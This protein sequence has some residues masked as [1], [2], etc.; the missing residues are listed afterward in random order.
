MKSNRL[1]IPRVPALWGL[2]ILTGIALGAFVGFGVNAQNNL[3]LF[4][5]TATVSVARTGT[6]SRVDF[7]VVS[8]QFSD[9]KNA[10]DSIVAAS[11]D[12]ANLTKDIDS[13]VKNITIK[14][15]FRSPLWKSIVLGGVVGGLVAFGAAWAWQNAQ[16]Y[17]SQQNNSQ[18][19]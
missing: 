18:G 6:V 8:D 14:G 5:A 13:E 3:P 19:R 4:T 17:L 1:P 2:F 10:V 7:R 9:P 11:Q 16:G 15:R 12:I